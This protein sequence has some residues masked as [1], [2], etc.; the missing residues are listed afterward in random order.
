[1]KNNKGVKYS[2]YIIDSLFA[3]DI[4]INFRSPYI[5]SKTEDLI[6]D[7]TRIAKNYVYNGRFLIDLLASMPLEAVS[8]F[9]PVSEENLKFLGML[10][11]I[12]LLRLGRMITYLKTN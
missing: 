4:I 7:G 6:D 10:K 12:R 9:I 5:D 2:D 3:I 1:M 8:L 11:L